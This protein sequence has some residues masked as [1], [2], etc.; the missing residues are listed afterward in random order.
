MQK[1]KTKL[2]Q[3]FYILKHDYFTHDRLFFIVVFALCFIFIVGAISAMTRNYKLEREIN[4]KNRALNI[5][6]LE[7]ETA[8]LEN[9]YY[10]SAEYQELAV[11][12][13]TNKVSP[14]EKLVFL[15]VFEKKV[16]DES[17]LTVSEEKSE[18]SASNLKDWL[19]FLL[20]I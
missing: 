13:S 16:E 17:V 1:T 6:E 10:S 3:W 8:R 12:H 14:G 15:P 2:R 20:G 4:E 9:D 5:L 19:T 18:D 7:I 11:K